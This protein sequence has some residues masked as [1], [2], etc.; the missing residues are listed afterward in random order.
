MDP[1]PQPDLP[2]AQPPPQPDLPV[3]QP[4]Q[5]QQ[6]AIAEDGDLPKLVRDSKRIFPCFRVFD[7][8]VKMSLLLFFEV[9]LCGPGQDTKPIVFFDE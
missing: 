4:P 3:A 7:R 8:F 5:P 9:H 1:P 2:V 6:P